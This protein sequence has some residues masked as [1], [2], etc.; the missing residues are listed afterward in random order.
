MGCTYKN[1]N[2]EIKA[3]SFEQLIQKLEDRSKSSNF[4]GITSYDFDV[5]KAKVAETNVQYKSFTQHWNDYNK[6]TPSA[7]SVYTE[8][9]T[10]WHN[11]I[12]ARILGQDIEPEKEKLKAIVNNANTGN[13]SFKDEDIDVV[14][15]KVDDIKGTPLV[16]EEFLY[17]K[18]DS[19]FNLKMKPDLIYRRDDGKLVIVDYKF[20]RNRANAE[21]N[22]SYIAQLQCLKNIATRYGEDQNNIELQNW[23]FYRDYNGMYQCKEVSHNNMSISDAQAFNFVTDIFRSSKVGDIRIDGSN[24]EKIDKCR[25]TL[26]ENRASYTINEDAMVEYTKRLLDNKRKIFLEEA[27]WTASQ[28]GTEIVLKRGKEEKRF[29]SVDQLSKAIFQEKQTDH[30]N[31][32]NSIKAALEEKN[33]DAFT[34]EGRKKYE[35][36]FINTLKIGLSKYFS[37]EWSY[38]PLGDLTSKYN[39]FMM[40]N[41]THG[42]YDVV[43][44]SNISNFDFNC[45]QSN[46]LK[47]FFKKADKESINTGGLKLL[48]NVLNQQTLNKYGSETPDATLGSLELMHLFTALA[49]A[50]N[51]LVTKDGTRLSTIGE[52]KLISTITGVEFQ[53]TKLR[54]FDKYQNAFKILN[55]EKV[56]QF[57]GM[58]FFDH[59]DL[60][61]TQDIVFNKLS[62]LVRECA[63][64]FNTQ[65]D[66]FEG[67]VVP[68][69]INQLNNFSQ[70]VAQSD[71]EEEQKKEIQALISELVLHLS[72]VAPSNIHKE[73]DY[74]V[75]PTNLIGALFDSMFFNGPQKTTLAGHHITGP[76]GGL[77]GTSN[78]QNPDELIRN[79]LKTRSSIINRFTRRTVDLYDEIKHATADYLKSTKQDSFA[80]K[81]KND[82]TIFEPLFERDS[83]NNIEQDLTFKNPYDDT[84]PLTDPQKLYLKKVL[85]AINRFNPKFSEIIDSTITYEQFKSTEKYKNYVEE[86][87]NSDIY[88]KVPLKLKTGLRGSFTRIKGAIGSNNIKDAWKDVVSKFLHTEDIRITKS[89]QIEEK[90]KKQRNLDDVPFFYP[91]SEEER[92]RI[93]TNHN[94]DEFVTNIDTL[95]ADYIFESLRRTELNNY[96]N[97][98]RHAKTY[99]E[100]LSALTGQDYSKQIQMIIDD[101]AVNV[102]YDDLVT[103]EMKPLVAAARTISSLQSVVKIGFRPALYVKEEMLGFIKNFSHIVSKWF[104][105]D[106]PIT[107][108]HLAK[109]YMIVHSSHYGKD[110]ALKLGFSEIDNYS[111]SKLLNDYFRIN[112]RDLS[113]FSHM[114]SAHKTLWN[115]D[116][117]L[118]YLNVTASDD[119]NR[120]T[121]LVAK[122]I[123]DGVWP[124]ISVKDK[125]LHYDVNKDERFSYFLAH[126]NKDAQMLKDSRYV[127]QKALYNLYMQELSDEGVPIQFDADVSKWGELPVPYTDK[128]MDSFKEQV[129]MMYGFY[130][131]EERNLL[132]FNTWSKLYT[133]F[134]T[135]LPGEV[136]R[137]FST[138]NAT[139]IGKY[140]Q[141]EDPIDGKLLYKKVNEDGIIEYTTEEYDDNGNRN[142]PHY[143]WK[144]DKLEG[145]A[146][147][148]AKVIHHTLAGDIEWLKDDK[149]KYSLHN[150]GLFL[151]NLI[152]SCIFGSILASLISSYKKDKEKYNAQTKALIDVG[153]KTV[154]EL[155]FIK[156]FSSAVDSFNILSVNIMKD[157]FADVSRTIGSPDYNLLDLSNSVFASISDTHL[158][159]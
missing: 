79:L 4:Y 55:R 89:E 69:K 80:Y 147:S 106:N 108:K 99:L 150:A 53:D 31:I 32:A 127:S 43:C 116:S 143:I 60:I 70:E 11:I 45:G 77:R 118:V 124:A 8:H 82:E 134:L 39:I 2:D 61:P 84:I 136:R 157:V 50:S 125:K 140:Q 36:D 111:I 81:F 16:Y 25:T 44:L 67:L 121:L 66:N 6:I 114:I 76:L 85:F 156:S 138:G 42:Y 48:T 93:L 83:N 22:Q 14:L 18:N 88:R 117:G 87:E 119:D 40:Y 96:L 7:S 126:R 130:N 17:C 115:A 139:S 47:R 128:Q 123:A 104:K 100:S 102:Y 63:K 110:L 148:T 153:Y 28:E 155:N 120:M 97:Y 74:N 37:S 46:K 78:Y 131:H 71:L 30:T 1:G 91:T 98:I 13:L 151:F 15:Q 146:I 133:M 34:T 144:G 95:V 112:G 3:D 20:V 9:G 152:I 64:N 19:G 65:F 154:N 141:A 56:T 51:S 107:T 21:H 86:I 103:E 73:Y 145:L 33:S 10:A 113:I 27:T 122:M 52:I 59:Y 135:W 105:N 57:E 29:S 72:G 109:A 49:S 92:H 23:I 5:D 101:A 94:T 75:D 137:Y 12:Q 68:E 58:N 132:Q 142:Q 54:N 158:L 35:T 62:S 90:R 24:I 129:G 26:N 159:D 149:N 41:S 38:V